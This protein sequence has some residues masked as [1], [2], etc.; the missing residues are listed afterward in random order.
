MFQLDGLRNTDGSLPICKALRNAAERWHLL[1][2]GIPIDCLS[3][4]FSWDIFPAVHPETPTHQP[5]LSVLS[6]P[7]NKLLTIS[8][9]NEIEN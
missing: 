6:L 1:T 4:H 5:H 2:A 9:S 3:I 7:A 8:L